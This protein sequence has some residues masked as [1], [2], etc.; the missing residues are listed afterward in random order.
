MT[1]VAPLPASQPVTAPDL[2]NDLIRWTFSKASL[3]ISCLKNRARR[4]KIRPMLEI[5][6]RSFSGDESN[7]VSACPLTEAPPWLPSI[8]CLPARLIFLSILSSTGFDDPPAEPVHPRQISQPN[9]P[10]A[11]DTAPVFAGA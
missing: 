9:P 2:R 3:A 6:S 10:P 11:P 8:P 7:S 1:N 4:R 5:L